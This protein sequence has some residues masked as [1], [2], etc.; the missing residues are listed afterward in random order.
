MSDE[1]LISHVP[2]YTVHIWL[3]ISVI[4]ATKSCTL[5]GKST[6]E[7]H[8]IDGCITPSRVII[9]RANNDVYLPILV[10][11]RMNPGTPQKLL[12]TPGMKYE[13]RRGCRQFFRKYN[14]LMVVVEPHN[15]Y[16]GDDKTLISFWDL[17]DEPYIFKE[18]YLSDMVP[19]EILSEYKLGDG[20]CGAKDWGIHLSRAIMAI[21]IRITYCEHPYQKQIFKSVLLLYRV[22]TT[23]PS[24]DTEDFHL[25]KTMKLV[26]N[27]F[28]WFPYGDCT[29]MNDKYL[30]HK[31]VD[32]GKCSLE[33]HEIE[34]LLSSMD[35][36]FAPRKI[37]P[38][39]DG[40]YV[41]EPGMSDRL[42]VFDRKKNRLTILDLVSRNPTTIVDTIQWSIIG[43]PSQKKFL[44]DEKLEIHNIGGNWCCG[45]FLILQ[46]L[47]LPNAST[48]HRQWTFK[49]NIVDPGTVETRP[50]VISQIKDIFDSKIS[51]P[52][53]IMQ[54]ICFIDAMGIVYVVTDWHGKVDTLTVN[55]AQFHNINAAQA[56]SIRALEDSSSDNLCGLNAADEVVNW[57]GKGEEGMG[58]D[59]EGKV[60]E[61]KVGKEKGDGFYPGN[62]FLFTFLLA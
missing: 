48:K 26:E 58:E 24:Q 59:E 60:A 11:D 3:S 45:S 4:H 32:G 49:L 54:E 50:E 25:L 18:H 47:E 57:I 51:Y 6:R 28:M 38:I 22:N 30:I 35:T 16:S 12:E 9:L 20:R 46:R 52:I 8:G 27:E 5:Q 36:R 44:P 15:K 10:I 55:C 21:T 56:G 2:V 14:N 17:R 1:I 31:I 39:L 62:F 19:S 61:E 23:E 33:V 29:V 43:Q 53:W 34:T 42:A 41:L 13:D 40:K 37:L 7:I